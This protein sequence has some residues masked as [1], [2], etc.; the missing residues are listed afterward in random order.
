MVILTGAERKVK[1]TQS[2]CTIVVSRKTAQ[3][4]INLE[5]DGLQQQKATLDSTSGSQ[6][7]K[8]EAAVS[9]GTPKL[10]R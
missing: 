8:A 10:D 7:Q 9:T 1:V 6:E 4:N 5:T 2:C 3:P